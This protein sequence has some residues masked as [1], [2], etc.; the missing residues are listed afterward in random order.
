MGPGRERILP[1]YLA[2]NSTTIVSTTQSP[3]KPRA[4]TDWQ[5]PFQAG[6]VP[7]RTARTSEETNN[8]RGSHRGPRI[9]LRKTESRNSVRITQKSVGCQPRV[10]YRPS[11][12]TARFFPARDT[13]SLAHR[14]DHRLPRRPTCVSPTVGGGHG[15]RSPIPGRPAWPLPDT[16][17]SP[18]PMIQSRNSAACGPRC[19]LPAQYL[20]YLSF[21]L[22]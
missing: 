1:V 11:V 16:F 7:S 19:L 9:V 13:H 18:A 2:P 10:R 20:R 12:V 14:P 22:D 21:S 17:R 6:L 4:L 5:G 8:L 15:G 3:A